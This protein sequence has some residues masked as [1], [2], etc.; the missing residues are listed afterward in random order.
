MEIMC[1]GRR[2]K[3]T[4]NE[5]VVLDVDLDEAAKSTPDG[6]SYPGLKRA[7]GYIGLIGTLSQGRV[8]YRNIRIKELA[9]R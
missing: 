6:K 1:R 4:L 8:E 9:A 2:A 3:V 5:A 7:K